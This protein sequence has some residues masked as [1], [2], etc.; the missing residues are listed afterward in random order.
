[1]PEV[2]QAGTDQSTGVAFA[3]YGHG[4]KPAASATG[5]NGI[6][7]VLVKL[8][9]RKKRASCGTVVLMRRRGGGV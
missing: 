1:L 8:P 5:A 6:E 9:E 3:D 2:V 4:D 7:L